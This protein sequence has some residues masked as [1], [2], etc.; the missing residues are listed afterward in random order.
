MLSLDYTNIQVNGLIVF[1]AGFFLGIKF[2]DWDFKL[3]LK[4]RS[5]LTHSPLILLPVIIT[6]YKN[7]SVE[8][9]Y[10]ILGLSLSIAIHL[11]FDIFPKGWGGG[12]LLKIPI[13]NLSLKPRISKFLFVLFIVVSILVS[14]RFTKNVEELFFLLIYGNIYIFISVIKEKKLLRPLIMFNSIIL[15]FSSIKYSEINDFLQMVYTYTE[16]CL[17]KLL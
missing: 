4:H 7:T 3:K 8:L 1:I 2:P 17:I 9:R 10:L 16:K 15:V 13:V 12:A 14:I 5:I 11:I 6:Y